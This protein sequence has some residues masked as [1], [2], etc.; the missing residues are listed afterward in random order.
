[1]NIKKILTAKNQLG[2]TLI[3][4]MIVMSIMSVL[5]IIGTSDYLNTRNK[6]V[7]DSATERMAVDIKATMDRSKAQEDGKQW[8]IRFWNP[9]GA[10]SFYE[11]WSGSDY[12]LGTVASKVQLDSSLAF[13]DPAVGEF[14]DFC[15]AKSTGLPV[16][17]GTVGISFDSATVTGTGTSF[18]NDIGVGDIIKIPGWSFLDG[19]G[20][21]LPKVSAVF[22][23]NI[24]AL[25]F[26]YAG[27]NKSGLTMP[28]QNGSIIINSRFKDSVG[29]VFVD[30]GGRVDAQVDYG[31]VGYWSFDE[32]DGNIANDYSGNGN[33]GTATN[34][35]IT[36]G[37]VGRA[38]NFADMTNEIRID[39]NNNL[40][41]EYTGTFEL[42][43]KPA[44]GWAGK[45]YATFLDKAFVEPNYRIQRYANTNE[46]EFYD[47]TNVIRGGEIMLDEWNYIAVTVN[48]GTVKGYIINKNTI[49]GNEKVFDLTVVSPIPLAKNTA[50]VLIGNSSEGDVFY[51]TIDEVKIY[52]KVLGLEEI[53]NHY[54]ENK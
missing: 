19:S 43:V 35:T 20:L 31:V 22:D 10:S 36:S 11:I 42:W 18:M 49:E 1:M 25:D 23:N 3:E 37:K 7:L 26:T 28:L 53:L 33:F 48:K 45:D 51:G 9:A 38:R 32:N 44:A 17:C 54:N 21:H 15:F 50:D 41:I 34:A 8:G 30:S 52:N 39:H 2:F 27:I 46:L 6:K 5:A 12:S 47:G 14:K 40:N 24:I 29:S 13:A 4:L 16:I